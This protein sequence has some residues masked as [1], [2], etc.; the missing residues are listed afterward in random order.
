[1]AG[2]PIDGHN[3]AIWRFLQKING[4]LLVNMCVHMMHSIQSALH[5]GAISMLAK[6]FR[7][8]VCFKREQYAQ[9]LSYT[10]ELRGTTCKLWQAA[11]AFTTKYN[12]EE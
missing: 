12:D 10:K 11:L 5:L 1:M 3:L 4:Q 7:Y 8:T 2:F 9:E 6:V